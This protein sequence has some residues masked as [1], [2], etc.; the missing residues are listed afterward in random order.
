MKNQILQIVKDSGTRHIT[1]DE[2]MSKLT[3][4]SN[5]RA[6]TEGDGDLYL[7]IFR[8]LCDLSKEGKIK[9]YNNG[10]NSYSYS[11]N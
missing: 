1:E 9:S 5:C 3:G 7:E 6:W 4:K 8:S 2:V 10:F 11:V